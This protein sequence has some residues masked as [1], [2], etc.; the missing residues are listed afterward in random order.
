MQCDIIC[1]CM[2]Y[3]GTKKSNCFNHIMCFKIAQVKVQ[4]KLI[5]IVCTKCVFV[6]CLAVIALMV[7]SCTVNQLTSAVIRN[8]TSIASTTLALIKRTA[9]HSTVSP[10]APMH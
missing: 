7:V 9:L 5:S 6:T 10:W 4:I 1:I 3:V 2:V 8:E